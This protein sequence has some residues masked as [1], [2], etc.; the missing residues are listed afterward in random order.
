MFLSQYVFPTP[1]VS[2][3]KAAVVQNIQKKSLV[4]NISKYLFKYIYNSC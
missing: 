4:T 1:I 2:L 3:F